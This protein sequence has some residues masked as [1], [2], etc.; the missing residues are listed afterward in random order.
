MPTVK[1]VME[2]IKRLKDS[3][4]NLRANIA[5]EFNDN[6]INLAIEKIEKLKSLRQSI[7]DAE[8]LEVKV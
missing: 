8:N 2:D 1:Q 5:D 3:Y 4:D 6:N 7:E